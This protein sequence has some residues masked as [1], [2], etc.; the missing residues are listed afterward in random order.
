MMNKINNEVQEMKT[1]RAINRRIGLL[2]AEM[3]DIRK[4]GRDISLLPEIAGELRA[5]EWILR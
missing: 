3:Q 4:T 5:L 1:E 2:E